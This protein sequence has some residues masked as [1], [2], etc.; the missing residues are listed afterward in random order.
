[1]TAA[2]P[3]RSPAVP[4]RVVGPPSNLPAL[5]AVGVLAISVLLAVLIYFI[6]AE[7]APDAAVMQ[8]AVLFGA[9]LVAAPGFYV[10]KNRTATTP[11]GT[12]LVFLATCSVLL[13][14]IY[15]FRVSWYVFFPADFL[16]WSEGDFVNDMLKFSVGYPLFTPQ[17]NNDSFE[18][19]PGAQ[20]LTYFIA[21]TVGKAGSI[22][23][24]RVI[25]VCYT[26]GAA[27]LALLCW[28]K[29]SRLA[30]LSEHLNFWLWDAFAYA[31]LFLIATN[32]ITNP[33]SHNLHGDALAQLATLAAYYL[34]LVYIETRSAWALAAMALVAPVG[35][36]VKQSLTAWA[37]WYGGFLAFWGNSFRRLVVFLA[38]TLV[39]CAA[40]AGACYAI[41]GPSFY[42]WTVFVLSK[43]G[44]SPLR[45][46]QHLLDAWT[47]FA[48]GILGGAALLSGRFREPLLGAW[49]VWLAVLLAETHTSG[50]AWM[51]NHM[52]PGCLIAGIWFLAGFARLW[53]RSELSRN[54][55]TCGSALAVVM[56]MFNGMGLIRI[57]LRPVSDDAYRYVRDI[58]QQ[59]KGQPAGQIL[60]D[61][62]TWTYWNSKIVMGDRGPGIGDR[63]HSGIGDFSGIISRITAKRYSKIL[64]RGFH[65]RDFI[66]D[67]YLWPKSSGI[68]QALIENYR[69]TGRIP[70]AQGP[71]A[72][73]NWAEDPYYFGEIT[74]LEP[75]ITTAGL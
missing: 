65:D 49:L 62:G 46:F 42:F 31:A 13:L 35:F 37:G 11:A 64:M 33:F 39:L 17:V 41:W 53:Q 24:Y 23:A 30:G 57:P 2:A 34:L 68:R 4:A 19:V 58:E 55:V 67:Y 22:P 28:R 3:P 69:E 60:M 70:A 47:Y 52:G 8:V 43:D 18:Y 36:M 6:Q 56:L 26:A 74:I 5:A 72:V 75:K 12:A 9:I 66:Y 25:Q 51:L 38:S 54:W 59:F 10:L 15:F 21:W 7:K 50:I 63:G 40:V 71:A 45:S 14:A 61:T 48:A 20:L 16:T 1:M 73:P 32:S 27:Y 29:L 44:V